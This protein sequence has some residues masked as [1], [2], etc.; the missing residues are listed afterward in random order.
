[1]VGTKRTAAE[2]RAVF[3]CAL[4]RGVSVKEAARQAGTGT[5]NAYAQRR[6]N[7]VFAADWERA[8]AEGAARLAAGERPVLAPGE[9]VRASARGA[10]RIERAGP[11]RW[12]A[13]K[14]ERFL[15]ALAGSANVSA[16]CRTAGVSAAAVY[17]RRRDWPGFAEKWADALRHGRLVLGGLLIET[18][19]ATLDGREP[20][21]GLDGPRMT[22]AE[23]ITVWRMHEHGCTGEGRRPRHD[24]RAAE[25]PIEEVRADIL[26]RVRLVRP[27]GGEGA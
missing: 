18:A 16:A 19:S 4:A 11:G 24:W 21:G 26:R 10:P 17:V 23:A 13:G 6:R 2:W 20:P 15:A 9:V 27:H 5:E 3:L 25:R 1:M 12:S 8:K 22:V 7:A 14:E